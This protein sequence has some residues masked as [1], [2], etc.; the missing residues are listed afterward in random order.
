MKR[1]FGVIKKFPRIQQILRVLFPGAPVDVGDGGKLAAELA[2]G[3]HP[4]VNN[5]CGAIVDKIIS[6]VVLGRAIV[7]DA[8]LIRE[9][10]G[11]GSTAWW[12]PWGYSFRP[13]RG[14]AVC[15]TAFWCY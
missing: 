4:T 3:N 15:E 7:S 14:Y 11:G 10:V 2:Y 12:P 5:H 9:V 1:H 6:G 8:Q 13:P